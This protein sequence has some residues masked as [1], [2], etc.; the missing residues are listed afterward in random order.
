MACTAIRRIIVRDDDFIRGGQIPRDRPF[1]ILSAR[2]ASVVDPGRPRDIVVHWEGSRLRYPVTLIYELRGR[3]P[4]PFNCATPRMTLLR[5]LSPAVFKRA[6]YC[7]ALRPGRFLFPYVVYLR[8]AAG[9]RTQAK[10]VHFTCV[11]R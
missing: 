8:D 9:R 5:F 4:P 2:G 11:V 6:Q 7:A 3:C 1:R 10:S